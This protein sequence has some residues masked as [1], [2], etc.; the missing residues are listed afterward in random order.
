M[1]VWQFEDIFLITGNTPLQIKF[2]SFS[3]LNMEFHS[4]SLTFKELE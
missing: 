2:V 4:P 3:A 1:V